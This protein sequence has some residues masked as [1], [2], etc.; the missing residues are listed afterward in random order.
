MC[1]L[2]AYNGQKNQ[3]EKEIM[4]KDRTRE[5]SGLVRKAKK[6]L[7]SIPLWDRVR[8]YPHQQAMLQ[9]QLGVLRFNSI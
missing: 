4:S 7:N 5:G 9:S 3:N 1:H 8:G 6:A 2:D